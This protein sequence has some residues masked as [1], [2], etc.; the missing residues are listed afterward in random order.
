[1]THPTR[2]QMWAAL[3][4]A[5]FAARTDQ[6]V[7]A[8]PYPPTTHGPERLLALLFVREYLRLRPPAVDHDEA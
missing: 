8:C 6:P 4:A 3:R 2:V 7:T 1:M 5:K